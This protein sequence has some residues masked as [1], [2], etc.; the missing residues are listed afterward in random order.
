MLLAD[1]STP[2]RNILTSP[3]DIPSSGASFGALVDLE[4][5]GTLLPWESIQALISLMP[6][7]EHLEA[8]FNEYY[9]QALSPNSPPHSSLKSLNLDNNQLQDWWVTARAFNSFPR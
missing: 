1:C 2:S 4:L 6:R 7:L 8:G 3:I 9:P 5:N